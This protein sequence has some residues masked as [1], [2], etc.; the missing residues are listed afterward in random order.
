MLVGFAVILAILLILAIF[1]LGLFAR[2]VMELRKAQKRNELP[3]PGLK[4]IANVSGTFGVLSAI[5]ALLFAV[6]LADAAEGWWRLGPLILVNV[7]IQPLS[8]WFIVFGSLTLW[9]TLRGRLVYALRT[10]PKEMIAPESGR[11]WMIH[12]LA[13]GSI[14][15]A[16]G[17]GLSY[18]TL[19]PLF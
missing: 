13:C 8:L 1:L 12:R 6:P 10:I 17:C 9:H 4:F 5:A 19:Q 2:C 7:V 14:A 3:R 15:I 18:A 11:F 16:L